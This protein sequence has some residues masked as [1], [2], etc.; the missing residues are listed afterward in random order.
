M[1]AHQIGVKSLT[2]LVVVGVAVLPF[3]P[4]VTAGA[5]NVDICDVQRVIAQLVE[6]P[7]SENPADVNGDGHVDIRDLQLILH[8]AGQA[9]EEEPEP[10][11]YQ[12]YMDCALASKMM[13][14]PNETQSVQYTLIPAHTWLPPVYSP[15]GDVNDYSCLLT[16]GTTVAGYS[17]IVRGPPVFASVY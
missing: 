6:G 13:R 7:C 10:E 3:H 9:D 4:L 2:W 5:T 8:L 14:A 15:H 12:F 1:A 11:F 17:I 16:P